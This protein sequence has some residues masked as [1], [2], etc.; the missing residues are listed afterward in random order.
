MS[1]LAEAMNE[2]SQGAPVCDKCGLVK[3]LITRK[4]QRPFWGCIGCYRKQT[5]E[6]QLQ[7]K[8]KVLEIKTRYRN[9]NK[10]KCNASARQRYYADH[11]ATRAMKNKY[12]QKYRSH[13]HEKTR[14]YR[15][16]RRRW[17]SQSAD[18]FTE[19]DVKELLLLQRGKCAEPSCR[20]SLASGYHVDHVIPVS[21]GG[22]NGRDN[23][24]ILCP[25]CNS[26]KSN[27]DPIVWANRNGRLF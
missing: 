8:A 12:Q 18:H 7:N 17:L 20:K 3:S 19:S 21:R 11:I 27:L 10:E 15:A 2:R 23:I 4:T 25:S 24:Q 6:W 22:G 14:A 16:M 9:N 5:R 26:R 1:T 13:N